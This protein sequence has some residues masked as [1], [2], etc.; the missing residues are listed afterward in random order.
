MTKKMFYHTVASQAELPSGFHHRFLLYMLA[1]WPE[2]VAE[3]YAIE[4]ADRFRKVACPA[5]GGMLGG[6]RSN[7]SCAT[8]HN[9]ARFQKQLIPI[10]R[11]GGILPHPPLGIENPLAEFI[12][13]RYRNSVSNNSKRQ[14]CAVSVS[15]LGI[16][17]RY[18]ILKSVTKMINM[19]FSLLSFDTEFPPICSGNYKSIET[20][21]TDICGR[22]Y[23]LYLGQRLAG[24]ASRKGIYR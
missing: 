18:R 16:E 4:W 19:G 20:H 14:N 17:T 21:L 3:D 22:I 9:S 10:R 1:R 12:E 5:I 24:G 8:L 15:K 2:G 7:R 13:T 6:S 23:N 11:G